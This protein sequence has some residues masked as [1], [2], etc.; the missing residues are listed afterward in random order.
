MLPSE[1]SRSPQRGPD[2][3]LAVSLVATC[4]AAAQA[5]HIVQRRL[6]NL[7]TTRPLEDVLL[8]I[9]EL[10]TNAVLHGHGD[11]G[12]RMTYDGAQI[13][14]TVSDDGHGFT[15]DVNAPRDPPRAGGRGLHVVDQ[16]TTAWGIHPHLSQVWFEV[17]AGVVG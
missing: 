1:V 8:I 11:V 13:A 15:H 6:G 2:V 17:S 16:L 4:G 7:V 3:S 14:G 5:R 10:V 9:S 12:I